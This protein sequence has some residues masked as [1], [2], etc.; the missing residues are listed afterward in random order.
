[1]SFAKR[2]AVGACK[3]QKIKKKLKAFLFLQAK[4]LSVCVSNEERNA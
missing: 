2:C 4:V 3:T 1:M